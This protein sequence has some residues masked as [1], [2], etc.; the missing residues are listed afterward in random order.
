[1]RRQQIFPLT[2]LSLLPHK[3]RRYVDPGSKKSL[4]AA[5]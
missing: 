3:R 1:L 5:S 4:V 2:S